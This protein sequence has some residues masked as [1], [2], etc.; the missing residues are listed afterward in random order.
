MQHP[1]RWSNGYLPIY[2]SADGKEVFHFTKKKLVPSRGN[3]TSVIADESYKTLFELVS[4][5]DLCNWGSTYTEFEDPNQK[6]KT[7]KRE[8]KMDPKALGNDVWRFNFLDDRSGARQY[9]KFKKNFTN[10]GGK[11]YKVDAGTPAK[12]V[13]LPRN[14]K[15]R[16]AWWHTTQEVE[17]FTLSIG[18]APLVELITLMALVFDKAYTC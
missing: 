15:R 9:Y 11:I 3:T 10:L 16:D 14:Q 18:D 7:P 4:S 6:G 2:A 5:N 1:L 8:Y 17:T 12:L 13:G